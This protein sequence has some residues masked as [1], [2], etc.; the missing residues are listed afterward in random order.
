VEITHEDI[1]IGRGLGALDMVR[2]IAAGRPHVASGELG[3]HVLDV[4]LSAQESA[5]TGRTLAVESTV[6]PVPLLPEGFDPFVATL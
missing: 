5:R 1:E 3:Y 4:L 6:G 2:A